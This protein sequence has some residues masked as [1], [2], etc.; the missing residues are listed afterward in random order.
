MAERIINT[1]ME[2]TSSTRLKPTMAL[3]GVLEGLALFTDIVPRKGQNPESCPGGLDS[4]SVQS[5]CQGQLAA[6]A[7]KRSTF[8]GYTLTF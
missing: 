4:K 7:A 2:M 5:H 1:H 6:T 3:R 8:L